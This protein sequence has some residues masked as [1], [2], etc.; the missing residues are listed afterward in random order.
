MD[1]QRTITGTEPVSITDAKS[2]LKVD[3]SSDDTLL[4]ALIKQVREHIENFTGRAFVASDVVLNLTDIEAGDVIRLPFPDI[5]EVTPVDNVTFSG[6][7]VKL[8]KFAAGGDY[9]IEYSTKGTCPEAVK[10]A[11]LK[12]VA[13]HYHNRHN[14]NEFTAMKLPEST[15]NLL[16]QYTI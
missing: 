6:G 15:Y 11:I 13:E 5:D 8:A 16:L 9:E 12:A 4:T 10:L 7:V 2:W 3:F 1:I 14:T